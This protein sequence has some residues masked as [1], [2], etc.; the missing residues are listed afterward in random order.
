MRGKTKA[1]R[2][3]ILIDWIRYY[4]D[5][6]ES[7]R[8]CFFWKNRKVGGFALVYFLRSVGFN[9]IS[10]AATGRHFDSKNCFSLTNRASWLQKL[11]FGLQRYIS[12]FK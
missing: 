12:S 10:L 8:K 6:P 9:M 11:R 7:C 3:T 2:N 1:R 4:E 5:R